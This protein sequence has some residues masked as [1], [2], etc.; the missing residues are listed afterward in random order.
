M[1]LAANTSCLTRESAFEAL[2]RVSKRPAAIAG[3]ARIVAARE[4]VAHCTPPALSRSAVYVYWLGKRK[5]W[6][7]PVLRRLQ[8]PPAGSDQNPFLVFRPREKTN[9]CAQ[10][11]PQRL[12]PR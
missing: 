2:G 7:K 10:Q 3:A 5:R 8:P 4:R 9:R 6:G 1:T 12:L 11:L